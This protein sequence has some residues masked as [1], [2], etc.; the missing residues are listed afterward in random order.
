MSKAKCVLYKAAAK[1]TL[2]IGFMAFLTCGSAFADQVWVCE[3]PE[4]WAHGKVQSRYWSHEGSLIE[5]AQPYRRY[6]VLIDNDLSI[7][8]SGATGM[9]SI[10]EGPAP[11]RKPMIGAVTFAIDKKT[12]D[13]IRGGVGIFGTYAPPVHGTCH[14]QA[15]REQGAIWPNGSDAVPPSRGP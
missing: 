6:T 2:E 7:V 11:L 1:R 14:Q 9:N 13:A 8:G 4:V 15:S 3:M 12:G 10:P 5:M